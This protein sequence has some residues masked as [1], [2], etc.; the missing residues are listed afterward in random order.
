MLRA[1]DHD[2]ADLPRPDRESTDYLDRASQQVVERGICQLAETPVVDRSFIN[3]S[4][5]RRCRDQPGDSAVLDSL[6]DTSAHARQSR[7][8][9]I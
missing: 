2:R 8:R 3:W 7:C 1:A 6:D 9:Q 5:G 4:V